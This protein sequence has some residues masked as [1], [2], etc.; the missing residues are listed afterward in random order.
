MPFYQQHPWSRVG[1]ALGDPTG[2]NFGPATVP[3]PPIPEPPPRR[4]GPLG[5]WYTPGGTCLVGEALQP[6][7]VFNFAGTREEHFRGVTGQLSFIIQPGQ[8]FIIVQD[9]G[10]PFVNVVLPDSP[11]GGRSGII[12][13]GSAGVAYT[14]DVATCPSFVRA[15]GYYVTASGSPTGTNFGPATVPGPPIP[16]PA[17]QLVAAP[18]TNPFLL[19]I[20]IDPAFAVTVQDAM[21]NEQDPEALESWANN[22]RAMGYPLAEAALR[23]RARILRQGAG[24]GAPYVLTS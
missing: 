2:T 10:S 13:K 11:A 24:A 18:G 15:G 20:G 6:I 23:W 21:A 1:Q 3:G 8:R 9:D 12:R 4:P 14:Q 17:P 5:E 19:D 16:A 22:A 7:G